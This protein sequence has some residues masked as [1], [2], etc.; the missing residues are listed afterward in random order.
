MKNY[1]VKI[2]FYF[3][4]LYEQSRS[5]CLILSTLFFEF[6]DERNEQIKQ[7]DVIVEATNLEIGEKDKEIEELRS[8]VVSEH[9]RTRVFSLKLF[10]L[11]HHSK[12]VF[13]KIKIY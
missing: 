5:P 1:E 7:K 13:P 9:H 10:L 12:S 4:K 2:I 8:K 11:R 3:K 6:K